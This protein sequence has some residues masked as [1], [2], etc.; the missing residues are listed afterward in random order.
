MAPDKPWWQ[1]LLDSLIDQSVTPAGGVGGHVWIDQT[2]YSADKER[3]MDRAKLDGLCSTLINAPDLQPKPDG[4]TFCNF[5][6]QRAAEQY[7]FLG[8][9]GLSANAIAAA[10]PLLPAWRQVP[11]DR[12]A[13]HAMAGGL[14]IAAKQYAGHGHVAVIAARPCEFS[15]SLGHPVPVIAN[16]GKRN[17]MMRVSEA[18]PP[19]Q[20]EPDYYTYGETA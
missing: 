15:G 16:V 20:G 14:A 19:S 11:G 13:E 5:A 4:T 8:L 17:G 7:G 18:F 3:T 1:R 6:V 10:L 2:G 9:R 12:A